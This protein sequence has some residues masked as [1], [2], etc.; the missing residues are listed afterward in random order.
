LG[1]FQSAAAGH[2]GRWA[3]SA[4]RAWSMIGSAVVPGEVAHTT[5]TFADGP[6][7]SS[8]PSLFLA[9][10]FTP[11]WCDILET[12]ATA[13]RTTMS[14]RR[15]TLPPGTA[16]PL[17]SIEGCEG[18]VKARGWCT[19]HYMRWRAHGDPTYERPKSTCSIEGCD[20]P[21]E[22]RGWCH[23]HY[24]RWARR[25]G[26]PA[27]VLTPPKNPPLDPNN[28]DD[29]RHGHNGYKNLGCRCD[30]C[31]L[32][33]NAWGVDY[34]KRNPEQREKHRVRSREQYWRKKRAKA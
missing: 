9:P 19:K 30:V 22:G 18:P 13:S 29:P 8:G 5:F 12:C 1:P 11:Q 14:T 2:W 6:G 26:D 25:G 3:R 7:R 17:C 23:K 16:P 32:A 27:V 24:R 33:A 15:K 4:F 34:R 20:R 21:V 31:R 28:P 10:L